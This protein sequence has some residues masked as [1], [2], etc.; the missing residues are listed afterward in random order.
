MRDSATVVPAV[1]N[2]GNLAANESDD[3]EEDSL[4]TDKDLAAE[5]S[6]DDEEF[7]L[8]RPADGFATKDSQVLLQLQQQ[9]NNTIVKLNK[10]EEEALIRELES[11][12][13]GNDTL[14]ELDEAL[15]DRT[16]A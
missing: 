14:K 5:L 6:E 3:N 4:V 16:T 11:E 2:G 15:M 8:G 7:F 10:Q 12:A 9:S 13:M 1:M